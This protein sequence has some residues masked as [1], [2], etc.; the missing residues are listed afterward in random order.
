M[1]IDGSVLAPRRGRGWLAGMGTMPGK[2][3][4]SWWRRRKWWIM[5]L[6]WLATLDGVF[7]LVMKDTGAG[8]AA[9]GLL[10]MMSLLLPIVAIVFGPDSLFRERHSG[11]AARVL[12]KPISRPAFIPAKAAARAL[13]FLLTSVA[14]PG[15]VAYVQLLVSGE[16]FVPLVQYAGIMGLVFLNLLYYLTLRLMLATLRRSRGPVLAIALSLHLGWM[17]VGASFIMGIAPW[18]VA[19]M[20]W[21]LLQAFAGKQPV[22]ACPAAGNPL[23]A[24]L[25]IVATGPWCVVFVLVAALRFRRE[26]LSGARLSG[27]DELG[28]AAFSVSARND[29]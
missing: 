23:P 6:L 12:T 25:P 15:A 28:G 8:A 10:Q 1:T 21:N 4:A 11:T 22:A 27:G 24:V 20:P 2:E 3:N 19:I 14:L 13:G 16:P 5:W 29:G 26:E 9:S 18:L 7:A 17:F